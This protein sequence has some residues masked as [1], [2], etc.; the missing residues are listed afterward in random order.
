MFTT[1]SGEMGTHF[2]GN[3]DW[4]PHFTGRMG[5][6]SLILGPIYDTCAAHR[7]WEWSTRAR[8]AAPRR[9]APRC[10]VHVLCACMHERL[11]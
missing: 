4:G 6:G 7:T 9:A 10:I 11:I 5:M 3:G 1:G 8:R 2:T